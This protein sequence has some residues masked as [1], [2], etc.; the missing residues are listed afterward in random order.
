MTIF[1]EGVGNIL[2]DDNMKGEWEGM[3]FLTCKEIWE[4]NNRDYIEIP[5]KFCWEIWIS[6]NRLIFDGIWTQPN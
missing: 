1:L 5:V 6:R 4:R 3:Y 2:L